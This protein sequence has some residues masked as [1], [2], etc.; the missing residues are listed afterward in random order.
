VLRRGWIAACSLVVA[1]TG[2]LAPARGDD[3]G[4][5]SGSPPVQAQPVAAVDADLL[6]GA[7]DQ[8]VIL[9]AAPGK[10]AAAATAVRAAGGRVGEQLPLVDGFT[11]R[12]SPSA[13]RSVAADPA[14]RVVAADRTVRL[15]AGSFSGAATKSNYPESSGATVAWSRG[16]RGEGVGVALIDT[17]VAN[18]ADLAG[19]VD[20][21]PDFSAEGDSRR[22]SYGHGTVM[23]G[24][25]AGRDRA[26]GGMA[27][28][29][30]VVS[31]KVA[32]RTGVT[33]VSTVLA[34][35]Q[36][37]ATFRD[38]YGI[39]VVNLSWG[40]ASTQSPSVD[41]L[42]YAVQRLWR[43]GLVVV[44]AAG[45]TGPVGGTITKPAD[46]PVVVAVGAYDDKGNTDDA[47]DE[48]TAWS[49]QGP[50]PEGT[51]KPDLVAPGRRLV[52][53]RSPG[54]YIDQTY[55]SARVG[56]RYIR[57]SGT[58]HAAAVVSG[59][60]ALLLSA[61]PELSPDQV[62]HA[63]RA[64]ASPLAVATPTAQGA[65]RVACGSA[66]DVDASAAPVQ[67]PDGTGLGS[68]EDSRGGRHVTTLCPGAETPTEIVGEQ[69]VRCRPWSADS[70]SADSWSADS[71][72]A[73]S[74]SADSWS[75]DS[76][77]ADS[78]SADSW[79][80]SGFLSAYWGLQTRPYEPLPGE[81][82]EPR[83]PGGAGKDGVR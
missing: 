38:A 51:A 22:D 47:D 69:D 24:V 19:R 15:A 63:L 14:V 71:W 82:S 57:G 83:P 23:A 50:T 39:R 52:A 28:N 3:A 41:P 12:L 44:T 55:R 45:N 80:A 36:W 72:S 7:R 8:R 67:H 5:A 66:M 49:S 31:V 68:L 32:G 4:S 76:W 61:R 54:S 6:P 56:T 62:K 75:A 25:I 33:D 60:A 18:V 81:P 65:G 79:S 26:Y 58:S 53:V 17:G 40:T 42:N 29:A 78:W 11:A 10:M 2:T 20:A 77:S 30:R 46:D 21:G 1:V 16:V 34:A 74:W 35:M 43:A 48:V 13:I 73:D 27:P 59:G 37:V 9:R 70:W 64:S